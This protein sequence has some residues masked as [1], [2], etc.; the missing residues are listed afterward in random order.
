[1]RV[2]HKNDEI[3]NFLKKEKNFENIYN[4]IE[5]SNMLSPT[6]LSDE[7]KIVNKVQ[8]LFIYSHNL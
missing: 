1:M 5:T 2:N 6:H 4:L 3:Y 7:H 8:N